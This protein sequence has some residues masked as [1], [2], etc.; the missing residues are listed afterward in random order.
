MKAEIE[1]LNAQLRLAADNIAIALENDSKIAA[2]RVANIE[3]AI[4][5]QK[6]AVTTANANSVHL[7]ALEQIEQAY[8]SQL[9]S[10]TTKYQEALSR[11]SSATPADARVIAVATA[12]DQPSFPKKPQVVGL[13]T[14]AALILSLGVV[15]GRE[16]LA[17]RPLPDADARR[18]A[19]DAGARGGGETSSGGFDNRAAEALCQ[20]ARRRV[21]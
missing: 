21:A 10:A 2:S 15:V 9:D 5:Q 8:R 11:Q 13:A 6:Q 18:C 4:D 17:D 1:D 12:P 14:V 20:R 3:V 19:G 7:R 16:L